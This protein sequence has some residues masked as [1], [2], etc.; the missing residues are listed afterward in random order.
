MG[1][2]G[3]L[4][5]D[6]SK[7]NATGYA[8][9]DVPAADAAGT[10]QPVHIGTGGNVL[11]V[12]PAQ[13]ELLAYQP[14]GGGGGSVS[15]VFGRTGAVV[16]A[17]GDYTKAQVGLAN[18]DNTSDANKPVST[19]QAAADA[20][21]LL[22]TSNLS[23]LS[24]PATARTNLGLNTAAQQPSS[25][26]DAAGAAAAAQAASQPLDSDL[27]TIAGL[28]A[29]TGNMIQSVGSAWASQT[30]AQVKTSL[31]L[32]KADVGLANV[33]NTSDLNKPVSTA[34]QTALDLKANLAAPSL[35]GVTTAVDLTLS[36]R[37]LTATDTLTDAATILV[38]AALGNQFEVT[39]NVAGATRILGT[40]SNPPAAGQTQMILFAIRQDG[41]GSRALTLA[42][43]YR[44]GTDITA[45]TLS[46]AANKTDYLGARWN[47]TDS[48]WD[49][50]A[51]VKGY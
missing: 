41:S 46:T 23:D 26:F 45:V 49:V 1:A 20:L 29:T 5:G 34:Q 19:L 3:Y 8:Q 43:G 2:V 22:A 4:G 12:V 27:T 32:V 47:G 16:A 24:N 30:P 44:L 40:P 21:R 33:T 15:S 48:V 10:L 35:T 14:A 9:G 11:T 25:A 51:F 18:V 17:N 50:I 38:N 31:V 7:L 28:T 6:P 13:P 42:A 36:G 39:L 37:Q